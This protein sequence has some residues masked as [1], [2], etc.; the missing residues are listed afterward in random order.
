LEEILEIEGVDMIQWGPS[1][2]SMSVGRP[3]EKTA[4]EIKAVERQ[5][6]ETA[7][8]MGVPAR[9]EINSVDQAKYFLDLGV[10]HFSI[11]S[12][13][14]V[15]HNWWKANGEKLRKAIEGA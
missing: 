8:K 14:S 7:L 4:P 12:E 13:L 1:D 10:R 3:G 9:A 15:L 5:V 6:F 11:G 2:Y